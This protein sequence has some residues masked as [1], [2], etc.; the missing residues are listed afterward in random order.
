MKVLRSGPLAWPSCIALLLLLFAM[1][2]PA[3]SVEGIFVETYHVQPK[4]GP[5]GETL[6]TYR[7]YVDLAA[8]C[9]LIMVFGSAGHPFRFRTTTDFFNDTISKAKYGDRLAADR[10]NTYP[11]ALDSWLTLGP[12]SNGHVGVPKHLDPDG[13]VITCPP[14]AEMGRDEKSGERAGI[15]ICVSDGLVAAEVKEVINYKLIPG[16]LGNIRGG[17]I[18]YMDAAWSV[19]GGTR[20]VTSE[21]MVLIAQLTTTGALSYKLN[22]QVRAAHGGTELY[23]AEAPQGTEI[24]MKELLLWPAP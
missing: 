18:H 12:A 11:G 16:Y 15:P 9:E 1:R 14:Y 7:V 4:G 24:L 5:N 13:S 20:G 22:L 23:V 3:Q 2:A 6:I 10:L 19:L 8:D 17:D 21:N